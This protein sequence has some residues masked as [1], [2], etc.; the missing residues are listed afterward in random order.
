VNDVEVRDATGKALLV[1]RSGIEWG[2]L[3]IP[4][5]DG[6]NSCIVQAVVPHSAQAKASS[7]RD[8]EIKDVISGLHVCIANWPQGRTAALSIRFDDSHPT[9]SARQSPSFVNMASKAASWS[10]QVARP[11][12]RA[13]LCLRDSAHRMGGRDEAG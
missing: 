2:K 11:G 13:K 10:I 9:H 4:L 6:V 3:L 12:S 5:P 8:K 7:S 1:Q